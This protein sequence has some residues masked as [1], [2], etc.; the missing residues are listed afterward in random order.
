MPNLKTGMTAKWGKTFKPACAL[1]LAGCFPSSAASAEKTPPLIPDWQQSHFEEANPAVRSV[2][3]FAVCTRNHRRQAAEALLATR[4]DS[5]EEATLIRDAVPS[6]KTECPIRSETLIIKSEI[7]MRGA[8]AEAIYRGDG[9]RPRTHAALPFTD[10]F[11]ES[12]QGNR[13]KVARWVARC[14]VRRNPQG[15]HSVLKFN[16]GAVGERKALLSLKAAFTACLPPGERLEISR[17]KFRAM[18]AEELY[19]AAHLFKESFTNAQG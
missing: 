2:Y 19:H 5:P 13:L 1:A 4:P 14:A 9:T 15:A 17:L 6:G 7:F 11:A 10:R 18:I 3:I 8:I 16:P 12:D